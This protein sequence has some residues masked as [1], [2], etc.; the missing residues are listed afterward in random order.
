MSPDELAHALTASNLA[1]LR[2]RRVGR[3]ML[4]SAVMPIALVVL[5]LVAAPNPMGR[6]PG[7]LVTTWFGVG[8]IGV[9]LLWMWRI[10]RADPEPEARSWRYRAD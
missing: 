4:V 2:G 8:G 5:L 1:A 7:D 6:Q 10:H 3:L 9:G